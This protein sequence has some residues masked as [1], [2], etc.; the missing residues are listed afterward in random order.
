MLLYGC[1]QTV[2]PPGEK[3]HINYVNTDKASTIS[4]SVM[5]RIRL[6]RLYISTEVT[7]TSNSTK[8]GSW[9]A[10]CRGQCR[11]TPVWVRFNTS[12]MLSLLAKHEWMQTLYFADEAPNLPLYWC[13]LEL[14]IYVRN[15]VLEAKLPQLICL[16][17][18]EERERKRRQT[19][20]ARPRLVIDPTY[21]LM[22]LTWSAAKKKFWNRWWHIL[23]TLVGREKKWERADSAQRN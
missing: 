23:N 19:G 20:W 7:I 12:D 14:V 5:F 6:R 8:T 13:I 21:L 22:S 10:N 9:K 18:G 15:A 4:V 3:K 11:P 1:N 17:S 16:G 2:N